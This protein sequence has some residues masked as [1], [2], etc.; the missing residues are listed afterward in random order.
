MHQYKQRLA[1]KKQGLGLLLGLLVLPAASAMADFSSSQAILHPRFPAG[2]PFLIEIGGTWPTDCH[3]GEQ[4]PR[5]ESWDGHTVRIGFDIV[6]IH[7]TCN[8][9][10]T[11]YRALVDMSEALRSTAAKSATL[12]VQVDFD[13]APLEQTVDLVCPPGDDCGGVEQDQ[14]TVEPGLYYASD[15]LNR[16]LLL[17]RQGAAT[18]I[19]PLVYDN[20]GNSTWLFTGNLMTEDAFFAEV[21]AFSGGDCFG[22]E[23]TGATPG[24]TSI[25]HLSVLADRPG[26]LQVKVNDGLFAEYRSLVFGYRTFAV[27]P[28]GEQTL[29]DLAGRWGLGENH[30]TDPPLGDLTAFL[31]AVFDL[32][33]EDIVTASPGLQQDGQVSY[34]ATGP[35]GEPIGQVLCKG[36][37]ASD[38]VTGLCEFIDPT[39]AAEPLFL[40]YQLAPSRLA[41]EYARPVIAIG[42]APG[43]QAVRLD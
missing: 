12:V 16:G 31:P 10:D 39:D 9:R 3:P 32:E 27:G 35:T 37:T 36:Q 23:S 18:A 41:I 2:G 1:I 33:L 42:R 17:A 34:L 19:Y 14:P 13:G 15:H 7:I 22:C 25:G 4:K 26:V 43:G 30:G 21:L 8:D 28:A 11:P 24:M 29:I 5:V 20:D 6:V 38:G 40:F